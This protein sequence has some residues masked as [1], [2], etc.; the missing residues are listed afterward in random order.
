MLTVLG[1]LCVMILGEM[2]RL[3]WS[4]DSLDSL[5]QQM[6]PIKENLDLLLEFF[7]WMIY[8]VKELRLHCLTALTTEL[9]SIT[10]ALVRL[11][12]YDVHVSSNLI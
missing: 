5:D 4:A 6:L 2:K 9:V 7:S 8:I 3:K 11:L 12:E 1:V 10:A